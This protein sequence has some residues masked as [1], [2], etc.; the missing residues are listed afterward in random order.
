VIFFFNDERCEFVSRAFVSP[1]GGDMRW[2]GVAS[3][4]RFV[5]MIP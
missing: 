4:E 2:T 1:L 5:F 3:A